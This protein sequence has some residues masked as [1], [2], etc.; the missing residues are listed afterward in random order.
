M[1]NGFACELGIGF[2]KHSAVAVKTYLEVALVA[3]LCQGYKDFHL[4]QPEHG[5]F[6]TRTDETVIKSD[7]SKEIISP[8][9]RLLP[10]V[11]EDLPQEY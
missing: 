7:C 9:G 5:L 10:L 2:G 4:H 6:G 11:K 8:N 1:E 3:V